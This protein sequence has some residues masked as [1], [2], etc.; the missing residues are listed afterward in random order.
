MTLKTSDK[1][2]K[3]AN[4]DV[5]ELVNSFTERTGLVPSNVYP[6]G[7]FCSGFV[8]ANVIVEADGFAWALEANG[9]IWK[10]ENGKWGGV[11]DA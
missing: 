2:M 11:N 7:H 4:E 6:R 1:F 10:M 5:E 8:A 3:K 9:A